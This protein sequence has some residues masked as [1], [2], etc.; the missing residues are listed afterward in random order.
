MGAARRPC[1]LHHKQT[2]RKP[3]RWFYRFL[4]MTPIIETRLGCSDTI[5][6]RRLHITTKRE[7]SKLW[8]RMQRN[9]KG[10]VQKQEYS[11]AFSQFREGDFHK[12]KLKT[13]GHV[14]TCVQVILN[15]YS[16]LYC[17]FTGQIFPEQFLFP[18]KQTKWNPLLLKLKVLFAVIACGRCL[19]KK[20][21]KSNAHR[22][23]VW[24]SDVCQSYR[25]P[26]SQATRDQ[27]INVFVQ[28][29]NQEATTFHF[30]PK[31]T[32]VSWLGP[33]LH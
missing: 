1:R 28:N 16:R 13:V 6:W 15:G 30:V 12:E 2:Q 19:P 3:K 9:G 20:K 32:S 27:L 23:S 5:L 11:P 33:K 31:S 21:K 18:N 26:A 4:C 17:L 25:W 29:T 22:E 7:T 8:R 14:P 24:S 10:C